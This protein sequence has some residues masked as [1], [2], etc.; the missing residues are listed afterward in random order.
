[1]DTKT[2]PIKEHYVNELDPRDS[3]N[4]ASAPEDNDELQTE[5]TKLISNKKEYEYNDKFAHRRGQFQ[6]QNGQ[7]AVEQHNDE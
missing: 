2:M 3:S 5:E 7:L 6:Q 4:P 1:M